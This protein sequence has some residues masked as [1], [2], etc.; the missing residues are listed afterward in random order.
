MTRRILGMALAS[1]GALCALLVG[2][3]RDRN[4]VV[5]QPGHVCGLDCHDHHRDGDRYVRI[6]EKHIHGE[7]CGHVWDGDHWVVGRPVRQVTRV[8]RGHVCSVRCNHHYVG[9]RIVQ[10]PSHVHGRGCGH[11]YDGDRWVE[12][13]VVRVQRRR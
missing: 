3:D 13:D 4:T 9:E 7:A 8:N 2:C 12:R 10:L 6:R 1:C 11:A 5:V